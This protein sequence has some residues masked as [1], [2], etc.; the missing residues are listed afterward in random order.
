M[1]SLARSSVT[2]LALVFAAGAPADAQAP[3]SA[4]T[5]DSGIYRFADF[6]GVEGAYSRLVR[7]NAM[8]SMEL[9]TGGLEPDA[10]Y[11]TWWVVFN[12][13]ER[14]YDACD[15]DDLFNPDGTMNLNPAASISVLFADG[16]MTDAD[17]NITF[18]AIL[19]VG[20]TLG[21]VIAGPGLLDSRKAEVHIVVRAHGPLDP[22]R[23][24]VQLTTF[25]PAPIHGGTCVLCEDVQFA[26][27]L[28]VTARANQQ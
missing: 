17:G 3:G 1:Y 7:T 26:V 15:L 14:C 13:P 2:A 16:A 18:N 25:E 12:R 9:A 22:S 6:S 20:R 4:H 5:T 27:H 11:T 10:P 19:P 8:I 21:E 28:P 24:W 23:A